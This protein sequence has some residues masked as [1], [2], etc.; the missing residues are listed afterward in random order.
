MR[1]GRVG[2]SAGFRAPGFLSAW[3]GCRYGLQAVRGSVSLPAATCSVQSQTPLWSIFQHLPQASALV[4]EAVFTLH[5]SFNV[6]L[7]PHI[8][9]SLKKM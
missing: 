7:I 9:K 1:S 8:L 4:S 6:E 3:G 2:G 5:C